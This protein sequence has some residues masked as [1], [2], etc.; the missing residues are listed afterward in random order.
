MARKPLIR[1]QD[2]PYHVCARVNNRD[3]WPISMERAWSV[4]REIHNE[5]VKKYGFQTLGFVMM[6]NHYHWL[7]MTPEANLDGGMRYFQTRTSTYILALCGRMN[8]LYGGRYK[9][10]V[11]QSQENLLRTYRYILMNPV[12]AGICGRPDEYAF[13][14]LNSLGWDLEVGPTLLSELPTD[15][16][17]QADWMLSLR[18]QDDEDR[19]RY[20]LRRRTFS[21]PRGKSG[22][23]SF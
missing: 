6:N 10:T 17:L 18:A 22:F 21:M 12:R 3:R 5:T 16:A 20:A 9:W 7:L 15:P 14:S 8:R 13:S 2:F 11:I 19:I 23:G 1:T 4:V